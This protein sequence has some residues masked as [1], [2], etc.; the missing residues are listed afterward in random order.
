ML[1]PGRT[2]WVFAPLKSKLQ[3]SVL[4]VV[5]EDCSFTKLRRNLPDK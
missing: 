3:L 1:A 4:S 2:F 5:M